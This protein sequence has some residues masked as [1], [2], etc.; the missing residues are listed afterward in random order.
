MKTVILVLAFV[1]AFVCFAQGQQAKQKLYI[2]PGLGFYRLTDDPWSI[3][4]TPLLL[5]LKI[6]MTVGK[7]GGLGVQFSAAFQS[8]WVSGRSSIQQ[9]G[10][11]TV[12]TRSGKHTVKT[13]GMGIFYERFFPISKRIIFFP[14]AYSQ[15]FYSKN[16][17][18][19]G[20][21]TGTE[22]VPGITYERGVLHNYKARIGV[23]LNM[24]YAFSK[25][26]SLIFRFAQVEGRFS[27]KFNPQVYFELPI[28]MGVKYSF[29]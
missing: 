28:L 10:S 25:S 15:F 4:N 13:A 2:N 29:P 6:G 1:C 26:T 5:D 14:S 22:T 17:E 12:W 8:E 16:I 3:N 21:Y 24:Q 7:R 11:G 18:R 20:I 9:P 27:Y 23:N 19:G